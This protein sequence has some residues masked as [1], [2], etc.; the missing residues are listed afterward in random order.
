MVGNAR[1][2]ERRKRLKYF[3]PTGN[4]RGNQVPDPLR[5]H[6]PEKI[7]RVANSTANSQPR[8]ETDQLG[9]YYEAHQPSEISIVL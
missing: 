2:T 9:S 7:A 6:G 3:R 8:Y 4:Y 5:T 1:K